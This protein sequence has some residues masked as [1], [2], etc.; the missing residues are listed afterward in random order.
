MSRL[1]FIPDRHEKRS[2]AEREALARE[3]DA[4]FIRALALACQRGEFPRECYPS[5]AAA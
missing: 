3:A 1:R 5:E 4:R 2:D